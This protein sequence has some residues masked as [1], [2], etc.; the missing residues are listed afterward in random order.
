MNFEE[1]QSK[2][3]SQGHG[4]SLQ[5]DATLLMREV[6]RNY[7]TFESQL[8]RRDVNEVLAAVLVTGGFAALSIA[9][10][11]WSLLLCAL[12][13]LFIG[14]FLV[15]DRVK[16]NRLRS[17]Q[18]DTLQSMLETSLSQVQHQ[19]WLLQNIL[20]WYL[21]PLIPG[22]VVFLASV[23]WQSAGSGIVEQLV[24]AGVGL[25]CAVTFWQVYRINLLEVTKRLEPRR[26]ELEELLASLSSP[27]PA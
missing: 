1:M 10:G 3:Q 23:A 25:I 24:I 5:I 6:Q 9:L 2:W 18:A 19:I 14:V 11:E 17:A 26:R 27:P 15:V 7:K 4:L 8:W 20:W 22:V 16:Q 13:G 12:G 21:L